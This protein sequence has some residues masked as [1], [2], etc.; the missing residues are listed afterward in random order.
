L[1]GLWFYEKNTGVVYSGR[2]TSSN[3]QYTFDFLHTDF[4]AAALNTAKPLPES[5]DIQQL[6]TK[7]PVDDPLV[8]QKVAELTANKTTPYEKVRAL[9]DYFSTANQ[10]VYALSTASGTSASDIDAFLTKKQ[11]YCEQYASA[12]AWMVRAA[13][14][15]A[16]VA[17]GFT[18]GGNRDVN[19]N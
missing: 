7:L 6:N 13:H 10:F 9:Y 19:H 17:F 15:P 11:G 14:I 8:E 2:E 12:L 4:T 18:R 1:D 3:K 16:R 5:D